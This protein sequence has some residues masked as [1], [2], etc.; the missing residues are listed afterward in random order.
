MYP[1]L[2]RLIRNQYRL[3]WL[4]RLIE[5]L[6][7]S[8]CRHNTRGMLVYYSDYMLRTMIGFL[9]CKMGFC[10]F[11]IFHILEIERELKL[12]DWIGREKKG[13]LIGNLEGM[14]TT[15]TINLRYIPKFP[16]A[17]QYLPHY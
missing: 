3:N 1:E 11:I 15:G 6:R 16:V 8:I 10:K 7:C 13:V 12:E 2:C 9:H 17:P 4:S 14:N 5:K